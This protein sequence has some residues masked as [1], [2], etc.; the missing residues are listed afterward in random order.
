[1]RQLRGPSTHAAA[2]RSGRGFALTLVILVAIVVM[3]VFA[4]SAT[5]AQPLKIQY[6]SSLTAELTDV[7]SFPI[8]VDS[9]ANITEIDYFSNDGALTR[10]YLH[11]V[12]QD[13]FSANGKSLTGV[14]FTF[15]IEALFDDNGDV[16]HA[17]ADGIVEKVRLPD[18]S[19]FLTSGRVDFVAHGNP[20]F[21]LT[22]DVG[23]TVNLDG[24][25][26]ALSP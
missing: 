8:T 19:L 20:P 6:T 13:T 17:F 12:E 16:V 1:M 26:A 7:C 25:C 2:R 10:A 3:A 9:S 23:A 15:N 24:F 22:P 14:P 18:G 5:A 11:V 21:I 4:S